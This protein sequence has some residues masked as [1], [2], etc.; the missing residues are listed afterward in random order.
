MPD[1]DSQ[2][3]TRRD[4]LKLGVSVTAGAV[5]PPMLAACGGGDSSYTPPTESCGDP[6]DIQSVYGVLAVT[7]VGS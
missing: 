4:F 5:V 7:L 3:V 1:Q 2:Y 6:R